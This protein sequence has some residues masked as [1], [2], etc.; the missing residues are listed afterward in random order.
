MVISL[1]V[2]PFHNRNIFTGD[3]V[4]TV[5]EKVG[6]PKGRRISRLSNTNL[7][8]QMVELQI[9]RERVRLAELRDLSGL[10]A[11]DAKLF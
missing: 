10:P 3:K 1:G 4:K 6:V 8:E 5:K 11:Q 9:L 7:A 2:S